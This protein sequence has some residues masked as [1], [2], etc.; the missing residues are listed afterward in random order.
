MGFEKRFLHQIVIFGVAVLDQ[1]TLHGLFVGIGR[2]IDLVHGPGIQT[3]VIHDSG[4][5]G[6]GRIKILKSVECAVK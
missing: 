6:W 2:Y 1:C 4:E 5:R 3:G